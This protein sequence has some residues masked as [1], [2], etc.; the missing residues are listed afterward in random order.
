MSLECFFVE[1]NSNCLHQ[2]IRTLGEGLVLSDSLL[3]DALPRSG[4]DV[5]INIGG[6]VSVRGLR[7]GTSGL[8]LAGY[9]DTRRGSGFFLRYSSAGNLGNS[10]R[11]IFR[12]KLGGS[13]CDGE[14]L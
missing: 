1:I 13:Q 3:S 11:V 8:S 6:L 2:D 5:N 14:T 7:Q 4:N 12:Q 9:N 10:Q